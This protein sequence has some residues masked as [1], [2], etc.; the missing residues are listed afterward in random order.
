MKRAR[1]GR[2]KGTKKTG[3]RKR[4]SLNKVTVQLHGT[5]AETA[6]QF[7]AEALATLVEVMRDQKSSPN[8]RILAADR[9]LDRA[10][11]RAAAP[12]V[13]PHREPGFVPLA[14][15]LKWYA[16]RDEIL[17][18]EGKIVQILPPTKLE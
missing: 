3:G 5:F 4:G 12:A 17:A 2:R 10:H 14:E 6:K 18:A 1:P 9:L 16:R 11:G 15:R 7:D 8:A 13:E